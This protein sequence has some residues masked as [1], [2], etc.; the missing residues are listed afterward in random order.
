MGGLFGGGSK[1]RVPTAAEIAAQQA[2]ADAEAAKKAQEEMRKK[3]SA[4]S[5]LAGT[6]Q[7]SSDAANSLRA[8]LLGS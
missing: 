8:T 5:Q 2:A 4:L 3:Q 6:G 7:G 1:P